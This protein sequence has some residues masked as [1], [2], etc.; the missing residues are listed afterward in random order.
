MPCPLCKVTLQVA[1]GETRSIRCPKCGHTFQPFAAPPPRKVDSSAAGRPVARPVDRLHEPEPPPA[2][3]EPEPDRAAGI[4]G[5]PR[6]HDEDEPEDRPRR[7]GVRHEGRPRGSRAGLLL[8]FAI[9]V[10]CLGLP[11]LLFW[12][13]AWHGPAVF[14]HMPPSPSHPEEVQRHCRW[15]LRRH[16]VFQKLWRVGVLGD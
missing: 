16:V 4:K 10:C 3:L 11:A 8:A 14:E 15:Y 5:R 13:L 6:R 7:V 2:E 12:G 1:R 9:I